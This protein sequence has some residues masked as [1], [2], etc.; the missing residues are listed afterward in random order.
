MPFLCF[1][2]LSCDVDLRKS[3]FSSL[4]FCPSSA[5]PPLPFH[6]SFNIF[7]H[8]FSFIIDSFHFRPCYLH[9]AFLF[10]FFLL[11]LHHF[12]FS[13]FL[14]LNLFLF[15]FSSLSLFFMFSQSPSSCFCSSCSSSSS[16]YFCP[17]VSYSPFFSQKH[18]FI[19]FS[20]F[21]VF[22]VFN[23]VSLLY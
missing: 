15:F 5:S 3:S 2:G 8:F 16:S 11:L 13:F 12:F 7:T 17:I 6:F 10:F 23:S 21:I 22:I 20:F 14:F 19:F 9:I 4:S 1:M 18:R